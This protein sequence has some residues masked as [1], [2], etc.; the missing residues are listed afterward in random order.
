MAQRDYSKNINMS[1]PAERKRQDKAKRQYPGGVSIPVNLPTNYKKG[2]DKQCV[3]CKFFIENNCSNW[4]AEVKSEYVCNSWAL[5]IFNTL[6]LETE[7]YAAK[8]LRDSINTNFSEFVKPPID[9]DI[10]QFFQ[11]YKEIFYDI[12]KR[13]EQSHTKLIEDS[14]DYIEN[15]VDPKDTTITILSNKIEALQERIQEEFQTQSHPFYPD[16]SI[17]C[18]PA[19][20]PGQQIGI[21]QNG[22]YRKMIWGVWE[23][24][25]DANPNFHDAFG[26]LKPNEEYLYLFEDDSFLTTMG[27]GIPINHIDDF[28]DYNIAEPTNIL[29]F[30]SLKNS[31]ESQSLDLA[32]IEIL[33]QLLN[34]IAETAPQSNQSFSNTNVDQNY[35][36]QGNSNQALTSPYRP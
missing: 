33:R 22:L 31:M 12:P 35:S 2:K 7:H 34:T 26:S 20:Q 5:Q 4:K 17:L 25:R 29:N 16:G 10:E 1:S 3:G 11:I 27:R 32:Q 19:G 28:N 36:G 23:V 9:E 24:W 15:Y 14:K 30:N 6:K 21:M 8:S 18:V 13:G